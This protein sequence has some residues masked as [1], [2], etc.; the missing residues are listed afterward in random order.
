ME[1]LMNTYSISQVGY[2][3]P[4]WVRVDNYY[5]YYSSGTGRISRRT[6]KGFV[7]VHNG[8]TPQ[9]YVKRK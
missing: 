7:T 9:Q 3:Q 4:F 8:L 1:L 5:V 2:R 6:S